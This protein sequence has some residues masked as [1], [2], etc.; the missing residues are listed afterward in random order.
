MGKKRVFL[1]ITVLFFIVGMSI[2][3]VSG[4]A[5]PDKPSD[6]VY[7]ISLKDEVTPAMAAYL[8]NKIIEANLAQADGIILDITTLGGRV[9]SAVAMRDA[10]VASEIPVAVFISS[11]AIS[12]GALITLAGDAI[13]MAPGSQMGDA[14]PVPWSEKALAFVSGEFHKTAEL[15]GRDTLIAVGM[16]DKDVEAAGFPK[17]RIVYLTAEQAFKYG[18]ADAV[19]K[20]IPEVVEFMGWTGARVV[21]VVPDYKIQIAQFLTRYEVASILLTIGMIAIVIEIFTQG[22]GVAGIVGISA[23]ALYFS[24]GVLA[25]NTEWWSVFLFVVGIVL[26]LVE[27]AVPGFGVF[28][29]GGIAVMLVSIIFA[30]PDPTQGII[31]IGIALIATAIVTPFL[32]KMLKHN[33]VFE[34]LVLAEAETIEKGYISVVERDHLLGALGTAVTPL[35]PA[36][37]ILVNGMRVDAISDGTFLSV[38]T[39]VKIIRVEGYKIVVTEDLG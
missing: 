6:T 21:D 38:G 4:L 14:E 17:G 5:E 8:E 30:A 23:Y 28:G 3:P 34:R 1:W 37:T 24:G 39:Q 18:Y 26:L 11:R 36:G 20:T 29:F 2:A 12:A 10:I 15:R 27:A 25:G 31:S 19:L 32:F 35:R 33:K 7:V 16:V 9:D 22:F 13:V